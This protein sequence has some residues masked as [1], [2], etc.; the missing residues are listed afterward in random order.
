M[1]PVLMTPINP[2]PAKTIG[3]QFRIGHHPPPPKKVSGYGPVL[4]VNF[5]IFQWI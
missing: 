3:P 1:Y 2:K 5:T 4:G